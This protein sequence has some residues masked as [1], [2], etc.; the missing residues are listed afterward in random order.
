MLHRADSSDLQTRTIHSRAPQA[1]AQTLPRG[2]TVHLFALLEQFLHG[3]RGLFHLAVHLLS[4]MQTVSYPTHHAANYPRN[5]NIRETGTPSIPR[6][7]AMLLLYSLPI[8]VPNT[9]PCNS[10]V[11]SLVCYFQALC[12]FDMLLRS[13]TFW[14]F[15]CSFLALHHEV[16]A[17]KHEIDARMSSSNSQSVARVRSGRGQQSAQP[18][19]SSSQAPA[20]AVGQICRTIPITEESTEHVNDLSVVLHTL[21]ILLVQ[22]A[23]KLSRGRCGL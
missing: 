8:I 1:R 4:S 20:M 16:H 11:S 23:V 18:S 3:K 10:G 5:P 7:A 6:C 13:R 22:L 12:H 15:I 14:S 21:M 2:T 9:Q 17:R 19:S